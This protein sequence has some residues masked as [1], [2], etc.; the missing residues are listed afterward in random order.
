V[1]TKATSILGGVFLVLSL[2][3]AIVNRTPGVSGVE[4]A[5]RQN[6]STEGSTW[7]LNEDTPGV[8][9]E[10]TTGDTESS[11]TAE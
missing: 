2:A 6:M 4:K 1:L 3:L 11:D 10:E 9:I 5:G 8:E 7:Y